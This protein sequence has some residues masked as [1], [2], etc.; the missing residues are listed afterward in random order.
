M[1]S[2]AAGAAAESGAGPMIPEQVTDRQGLT[3]TLTRAWPSADGSVTFEA[4]SPQSPHVRGGRL[5]DADGVTLAPVGSDARLPEL[6]GYAATGTVVVHRPGRRAVVRTNDGSRFIK[7]VRPGR[8]ESV[9]DAAG[10]ADEFARAF[11]VPAVLADTGGSV[12]FAALRG[13]TVHDLGADRSLAPPAWAGLWAEW[14]TAW[15]AVIGAAPAAASVNASAA[16]NNPSRFHSAEAEV[17]VVQTWTGHAQR[18]LGPGA[19]ATQLTETAERVSALLTDTAADPLVSTHRDLHD[20]QLLW[21]PRDG[22]SLLDLDTATRGEAALD[23]GNMAAHVLLR[24]RQGLWSAATA[25]TAEAAVRHTAARLGVNP[26]RLHAYEMAARF[27]ITCVYAY[28]PRWAA[29]AGRLQS[30]LRHQLCR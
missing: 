6:A 7:V 18:L 11:R 13:R 20:K 30:E 15:T 22:L 16:R 21:H 23:L 12:H 24:Q 27:R 25:G 17:D 28:R 2:P 19:A 4:A 29:L 14:A 26:E 8:A 10:R 1:L 9:L 5:T 3:W